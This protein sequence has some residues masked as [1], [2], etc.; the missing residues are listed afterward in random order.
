[1][2]DYTNKLQVA[3]VFILNL[4]HFKHMLLFVTNN[5]LV[6]TT[7]NSQLAYH[8]LIFVFVLFLLDDVSH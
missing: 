3:F 6:E 2:V 4:D 1:M 7:N 8:G 5:L